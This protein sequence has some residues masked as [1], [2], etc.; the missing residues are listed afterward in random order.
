MP[1]PGGGTGT[2]T[3]PMPPAPRGKQSP[4]RR[5]LGPTGAF[6]PVGVG[7]HRDWSAGEELLDSVEELLAFGKETEHVAPAE[8]L[9][10]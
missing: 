2:L 5:R 10:L 8:Y 4:P 7:Q 9:K 6:M 3:V 1:S